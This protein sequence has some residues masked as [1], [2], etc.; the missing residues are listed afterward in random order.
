MPESSHDPTREARFTVIYD[1]YYHRI[2]GYAARRTSR[3][4]APEGEQ[5]LYWL[6]AVARRVLANHRRTESRR[7]NLVVAIENE[8]HLV[9]SSVD[10]VESGR[11]AAAFAQLRDDERELLLLVAWEELDGAAVA[12]VLGCSR[13]AAR[14]RV[15]R[16]RR[17]FAHALTAVDNVGVK[18]HSRGGHV[19]S[20]GAPTGALE[21][22]DSP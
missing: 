16:A 17:R 2:L 1:A 12:V 6:Y 13:N 5:A 19:V 15:H 21:Q 22:E 8:L 18:R 3:D 14:I 4:D 20:A 11:I 9:S 7:A 10:G